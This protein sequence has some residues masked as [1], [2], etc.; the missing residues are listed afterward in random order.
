MKSVFRLLPVILLLN[1]SAIAQEQQDWEW[2][3]DHY[4]SVLDELLPLQTTGFYLGYRSSGDVENPHLEYSFVFRKTIQDNYITVT[5]RQADS[6]PLIDQMVALHIKNRTESIENLIKQLKVKE[7]L[8][9]ERTCPVV[10]KQYD[11][12]YKQSLQMYSRED[13]ELEAQGLIT[14][15]LHPVGHEFEAHISGGVMRLDIDDKKH[16]FVRWADKTR[17]A[18]EACKAAGNKN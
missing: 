5:V 15:R 6:T 13:R 4:K 16:P 11:E 17:V 8:L 2:V 18:L 9:S 12:F 10:R 1:I 14:I 7:Y 3:E